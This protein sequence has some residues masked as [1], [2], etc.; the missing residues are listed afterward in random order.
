[1]SRLVRGCDSSW[2]GES[3]AYKSRSPHAHACRRWGLNQKD[4]PQQPVRRTVAGLGRR[5]LNGMRSSMVERG[6][7]NPKTP[8][9]SR[10]FT[11]ASSLRER[12]LTLM[13]LGRAVNAYFSATLCAGLS[14]KLWEVERIAAQAEAPKL[15]GPTNPTRK[16]LSAISN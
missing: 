15:T 4:P 9:R 13:A 8:V 3:I 14:G 10:S 11:P 5:D 6:I 2:G 7:G 1:M 12:F 16:W